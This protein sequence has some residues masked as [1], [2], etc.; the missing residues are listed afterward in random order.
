MLPPHKG[1]KYFF[2]LTVHSKEYSINLNLSLAFEMSYAHRYEGVY[3]EQVEP[4]EIHIFI[5]LH[6]Q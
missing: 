1:T 4:E 6:V 5:Q 3:G 2:H